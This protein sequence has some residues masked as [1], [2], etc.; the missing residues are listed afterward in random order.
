MFHKK[1]H[2]NK[3][4]TKLNNISLKLIDIEF[5]Y[6]DYYPN[7]VDGINFEINH[8][9]YVTIIG[10]NGSGKSTIGKIIIG[11]L[12]PQK[13]IIKIFGNI[14]NNSNLTD[15]R[16]FL[17]IVFQNPDN[18]FIGSTVKDD[19]AFGLE[20]RQIP[21]KEMQKIIDNVAK[22]VK[23][24]NF[25]EHKPLMLSGGQKQ[26]V[27]IAST[28]A[29][30]PDIIIFDEA[31]SMLDPRG[32]K[33]IKDIMIKLK[34]HYKKTIISITHDMEEIINSDKIIVMNKGKIIRYGKSE[35]ILFD[36]KLLQ[37]VQLDIP[38]ISKVI[39]NLK[40]NGLNIKNTLNIKELINEICQTTIKI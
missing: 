38:F 25:L 33:E 6:N 34:N 27:A 17:G 12:K 7:A 15:I 13:G 22:Q 14:I 37:S 1:Q 23:M 19:I 18:Q 31:T 2:H 10:H 11:V 4:L 8:G 30:S 3:K 39:Y 24:E 21:Q 35:D 28:L 5:K 36:Q 20:N 9:E 40:K 32:K 29:L 26:K 16:Q